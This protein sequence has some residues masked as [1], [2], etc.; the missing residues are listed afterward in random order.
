[1]SEQELPA[2]TM[3]ATG[4]ETTEPEQLRGLDRLRHGNTKFVMASAAVAATV[5]TACETGENRT[6]AAAEREAAML[7]PIEAAAE[8]ERTREQT[9][10]LRVLPG[11]VLFEDD[12]NQ[13][14]HPEIINT[15]PQQN[16]EDKFKNN[17]LEHGETQFVVYDRPIIKQNEDGEFYLGAYPEE[18]QDGE[19]MRWVRLRKDTVERM[20]FWSNPGTGLV[21]Y[22]A[23]EGL[24]VAQTVE[25]ETRRDDQEISLSMADEEIPLARTYTLGEDDVFDHMLK[26]GYA[27]QE[28][29]ASTFPQHWE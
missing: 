21:R 19:D 29:M 14:Q 3:Y 25:A 6:E 23:E 28:V 18:T 24:S 26:R 8:S 17:R 1:M 13:R 4:P 11:I 2:D 5:L 27:P 20:Q 10:E 16:Y 15:R 7:Q 9:V 22:H 12:V